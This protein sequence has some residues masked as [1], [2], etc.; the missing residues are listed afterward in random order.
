MPTPE[1]AFAKVSAIKLVRKEYSQSMAHRRLPKTPTKETAM[2]RQRV[3]SLLAVGIVCFMSGCTTSLNA[4][5]LTSNEDLPPAGL[6]YS[7]PFTQYTITVTR[8]IVSC[9]ANSTNQDEL[10]I[11][12]TAA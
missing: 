3:I 12:M 5:R 10:V 1:I 4:V 7:L 2:H 11:A 9:A 8:R 6:P